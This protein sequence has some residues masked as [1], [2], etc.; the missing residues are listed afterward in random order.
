MASRHHS[1]A[2]SATPTELCAEV[3]HDAALALIW[4]IAG[5]DGLKLDPVNASTA[6]LILA[7][8]LDINRPSVISRRGKKPADA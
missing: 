5:Y 7:V 1:A 3:P 4:F 8:A 2:H 6:T